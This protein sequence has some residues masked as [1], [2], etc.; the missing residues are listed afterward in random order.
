MKHDLDLASVIISAQ[1]ALLRSRV[2]A[3]PR[4][5]RDDFAR[6]RATFMRRRSL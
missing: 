3:F 1:V 6:V 2:G 4:M 5:N